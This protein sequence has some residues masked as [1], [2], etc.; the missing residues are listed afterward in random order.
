MI[1]DQF[2]LDGKTAL[3]T[4][5]R[6]GIGRAMAAALAEAGAGI[7]ATSASLTPDSEIEHDVTAAGRPFRGYSCDL[8]DRSSIYAFVET[9]ERECPPIDILV[10]N[11]GAVR[12][13]PAEE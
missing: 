11:A 1:L 3:V 10:N 5:A 8:S 13:K 4:G 7:V 2:R 12:R 6:R 9:V